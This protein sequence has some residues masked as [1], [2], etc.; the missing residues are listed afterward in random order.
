[1]GDS[2]VIGEHDFD[3]GL[4]AQLREPVDLNHFQNEVDEA[5]QANSLAKNSGERTNNSHSR[6]EAA[7]QTPIPVAIPFKS[8]LT[9][10]K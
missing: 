1:M 3:P 10:L 5:H 8:L 2:R 4:P 6:T 7:C 9:L